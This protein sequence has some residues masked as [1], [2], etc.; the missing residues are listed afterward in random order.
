MFVPALDF[1]SK[2]SFLLA[3]FL[4]TYPTSIFFTLVFCCFWHCSGLVP[5]CVVLVAT[6]RAL[7]MHGGGPKVVAGMPLP[8]EYV[9]ENLDLV[10]RGCSNLRKQ[11]ENAGKFGVP[12]VVAINQFM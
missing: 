11:I 7:K 1:R 3:F 12:V 9:E 6:I 2:H 10:Q 5:N 8:K 4:V